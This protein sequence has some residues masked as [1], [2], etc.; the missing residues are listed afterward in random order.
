MEIGKWHLAQI[1]IA[2]MIGANISDPLMK[3]FVDQLD[4]VNAAAE[5]SKG[6]VWRLKDD[7]N[8]ATSINPFEDEQLI[9]NMSVWESIEDLYA[10]VY[11][12]RHVEVLKRR[13]DW[14]SKM[15]LFMVMWYVPA[16]IIPTV[17]EAKQRLHYLEINGPSPYAFDFKQRFA[18]VGEFT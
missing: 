18:P 9:V 5:E 6:F 1:N 11:N 15:K 8:N 12:G 7:N 2:K 17:E 14:F 13:K 4:E 10:F 16:G 3:D